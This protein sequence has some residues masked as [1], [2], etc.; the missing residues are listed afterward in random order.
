L[1]VH[2]VNG[3]RQTKIHTAQPLMFQPRAL[4]VEM[5]TENLKRQKSP[6]IDQIPA[7]LIKVEDTKIRYRSSNVLILFGIR[8][9]CLTC[10]RSP[11]FYLSIRRVMKQILLITE[12]YNF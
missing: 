4:E 11:S 8:R 2:G 5:A 1:N 12:K 10:V 3:V 7:E 9:N 6:D